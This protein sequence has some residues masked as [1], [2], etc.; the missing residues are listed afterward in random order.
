MTST[1]ESRRLRHARQALVAAL[2]LCGGI[3]MAAC[4]AVCLPSEWM[5]V[6]Y[7]WLRF[8]Q[9]PEAALF[10]YL[11]RSTS[12]LWAAHGAVVVF[13]TTDID[14]YLPLVRFIGWLTLVMGAALLGIDAVERLPWWWTAVEGPIVLVM[15][16]V[17]LA[18][19]RQLQRELSRSEP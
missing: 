8:G 1:L 11:A 13:L 17:F 15:G 18:A 14:R 2:R 16:A 5:H 4:L 10:G 6:G 19:S 3:E 12:L 9:M 7:E